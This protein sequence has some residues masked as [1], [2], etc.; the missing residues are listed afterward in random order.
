MKPTPKN[1]T[2]GYAES[3]KRERDR[4]MKFYQDTPYYGSDFA[5]KLYSTMKQVIPNLI[6]AAVC[7]VS[8]SVTTY[9][10]DADKAAHLLAA[11]FKKQIKRKECP[12]TKYI[13]LHF[14]ND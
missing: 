3:W 10:Q 4:Q 8:I 11:S 12:Y 13:T 5:Q 14:M 7:G 6:Q 1:S 9:K 2:A